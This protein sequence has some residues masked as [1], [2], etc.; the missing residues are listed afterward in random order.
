LENSV[1]LCYSFSEGLL[2]SRARF[3]VFK[4]L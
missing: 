4:V 2:F 3:L 1:E